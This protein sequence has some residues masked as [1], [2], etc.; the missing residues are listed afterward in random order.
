MEN[1]VAPVSGGGYGIGYAAALT[2]TREKGKFVMTGGNRESVAET[3]H[4]IEKKGGAAISPI[5]GTLLNNTNNRH[6][7]I[8]FH[9]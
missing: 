9:R 7:N 1:F 8:N 2:C 3:T 6:E 5:Q 4:I